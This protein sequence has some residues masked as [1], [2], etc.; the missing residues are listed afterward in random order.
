MLVAM[1]VR[2]LAKHI[3]QPDNSKRGQESGVVVNNFCPGTVDTACDNNLPW[4]LRILMNTNRRLRA[5][6]VEEGARTLVYGA[7]LSGLEAHGGY[8]ADNK[9]GE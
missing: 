2:E 9:V 4:F 7:V 3:P 6:T 1:F 8:M 5:R